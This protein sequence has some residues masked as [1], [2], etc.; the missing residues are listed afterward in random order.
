MLFS[1]EFKLIMNN[2]NE[3]IRKK[4]FDSTLLIQWHVKIFLIQLLILSST[5]QH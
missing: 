4:D 2:H 5:H 1:F 3:I